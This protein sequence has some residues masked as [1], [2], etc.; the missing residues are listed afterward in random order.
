MCRI[1]ATALVVALTSAAIDAA[2]SAAPVP[3]TL[4]PGFVAELVAGPPLVERPMMAGF[5]D[6][7]RLFVCDSSGF[8]LMKGSSEILVKDPPHCIRM[9]EDTDGDGRFDTS[10]MFADKMTFPMGAVWLDGAV[11]TC[12]APSLW[13]LEDTDD[14]GVADRRTPV[15]E[16]FDF[17]GNACD[18]HGPFL[19][20]DG[21]LHWNACNRGFDIRRPDGPPLAG[22]AA[23]VF[24]MRPDGREVEILA[25]GGMD[26]PVETTFSDEGDAFAT[27]NIVAG[28][29]HPRNDGIL[30]CVDG[31]LFPYRTVGPEFRRTG[32]LLPT[33]A[34]LGWCAPSGLVRY[35][36]DAFGAAHRDNLFSAQFNQRRVQRHVVTRQGATFK[37]GV[38]DFAVSADRDFHPT[39][40]L[41]DADGS[42]LLLDTGA[43][44]LRG[45]PTS[46]IA[47]PE[48]KGAIYRIRREGA[49]PPAD[50]RG[51]KEDWSAA[52]D[53][54]VKL[55]DDPRWAVRD[56]AVQRLGKAG[57]AAEAAL[58]KA[59]T[60]GPSSQARRNAVWALCRSDSPAARAA[61]RPALKDADAS[62]RQAAAHA[63]GLH[64]D[65]GGLEALAA[66]AA[67]DADDA[68][69]REAATALGRIGKPEAVPHLLAALGTGGDRF[70]EHAR[71]HALIEIA[72]P[73]ATAVGLR[74]SDPGVQRASLVALDQMDVRPVDPARFDAA[75]WR[76]GR[77]LTR[78][79]VAPL[80]N[81]PDAA[82]QRTAFAIVAARPEWSAAVVAVVREWLAAPSLSAA[83]RELLRSAVLACSRDASLQDA[84]GAALQAGRLPVDTRILLLETLAQT[85]LD[86]PAAEL[87]AGIARCLEDA[88]PRVVEQA[89]VTVRSAGSAAFDAALLRLGGDDQRPAEIRTVALATVA[90]RRDA[91]D[92]AAFAFLLGRL[93]E[94]V[95]PLSRLAA[96]DALG[97]SRLS[98]AQLERLAAALETA[99]VMEAPRLLAA[100][101]QAT[102]AEVGGRLVTA[103]LASP[104]AGNLS[105]DALRKTLARFPEAVRVSAA[106]LFARLEADAE[107][108]QARLAELA[109]VLSGGDAY[110]GRGIF[111]GNRAGCGNCHQVGTE[112]GRIGPNLSQIGT[113]RAAR[114]LLEAIVWPSA[115]IVRGY[116]PWTVVTADGRA[117]TG[118]LGRDTADAI[119]VITPDRSEVRVARSDIEELTPGRVSIMPQGLDAQLTRAELADLIAYLQSLK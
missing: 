31:G 108:Q 30:H 110:R 99:G 38:E 34:D 57:V 22:H 89:V 102:S 10:T 65:A 4:P 100:F 11:Y 118:M 115:S 81:S 112:G 18:I 44:F 5:D 49:R 103:L 29:P 77:P 82:L 48:I 53:R 91:T 96:A 116:E 16:K 98:D 94:D 51:L 25:A 37:A 119:Y 75:K 58:A 23:A 40:I 46:Q 90:P 32:D 14:D 17:G 76:A 24:R 109:P 73:P 43:W 74:S 86:K 61:V 59:V 114:D 88:D 54:L 68:V 15:V 47:K 45:C 1:H 67:A 101:E 113:I 27:A 33:V 35:R 9:L 93:A 83:S 2:S 28:A 13:R 56:R 21:R 84:V 42:L 111:Y 106:P 3:F 12:S 41:E 39:D 85:P 79:M 36:G 95:P 92:D 50:P 19:G 8:N 60:D 70:L 71:I 55:L 63:V 64:R 69:R 72:D 62:V 87:A 7:G 78:E 20:P 66:I 104:A 26:N 107:R 52:P 117:I 97:R 80:L 105:V 6:R